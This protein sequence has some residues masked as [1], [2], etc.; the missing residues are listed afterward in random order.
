V[1]VATLFADEVAALV[2]FGE[3]AEAVH[4]AFDLGMISAEDLERA[5]S[6][7]TDVLAPFAARS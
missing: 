6:T 4:R 1:S 3:W 5:F 7:G 2:E